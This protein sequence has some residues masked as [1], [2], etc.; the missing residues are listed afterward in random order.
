MVKK[1]KLTDF[2]WEVLAAT[3][4][5]PLGRTRTYKWVAEKIGRPKAMRA[6]GQALRKNPYPLIIPCSVGISKTPY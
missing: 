3:L 6:V 1:E 4:S 2:E 5:I